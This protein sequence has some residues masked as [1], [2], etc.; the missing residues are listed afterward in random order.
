LI[1]VAGGEAS[2]S[3]SLSDAV[4]A[5]EDDEAPHALLAASDDDG[6]GDCD[7][8]DIMLFLRANNKVGL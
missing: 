2:I 8:R 6:V 5:A 7:I 3:G 4:D 1:V